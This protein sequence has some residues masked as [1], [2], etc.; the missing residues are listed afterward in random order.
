MLAGSFSGVP[1][2]L[3]CLEAAKVPDY[4]LLFIAP[5]IRLPRFVLTALIA[6]GVSNFFSRWLNVRKRLGLL[7]LFWLMFY[8]AY[9]AA[10]RGLNLDFIG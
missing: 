7:A 2:K 4:G 1:F 6:G 5:F 3:Y 8:C 10:M 9:F